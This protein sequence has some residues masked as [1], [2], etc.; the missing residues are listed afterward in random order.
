V[1]AYLA[2]D[3]GASSG[4]AILGTL[5]HGRIGLD[6]IHR[7]TTPLIE[8]GDHLTWD[9]D[10]LWDE[11]RLGLDRAHREVPDLRSVSVDSWAVDYVPVG[12]GGDALRHPYSYRDPRT[13]GRLTQVLSRVPPAELYRRTGIQLLEINTIYQLMADL[14]E[15][16]EMLAKTSCRLTIADYLLYRMSG[17]AGIERTMAS[18]TQLM[19]IDGNWDMDL[20]RR[21]GLPTTGWPEII[22]SGTVL[23]GLAAWPAPDED[24][25]LVIAS[26]SHDTAAAVAAVPASDEP[27]WAYLSSGTWSLMGVE[28]REPILTDRAREENFTNEAGLDDTFRVLKNLTGLWV[29][30]EC[31]REWRAADSSFDTAQVQREA[32]SVSSPTHV[33]DLNDPR[34]AERGNMQGKLLTCC[35]ELGVHPPETRAELVRLIVASLAVSHGAAL[36][37][38]EDVI[39]RRIDVLHVVGGG[40]QN[41]LLCDL[42]AKECGCRVVAGPAEATAIGNLLVQARTLGDLPEGSTLRDVVRA[43]TELRAYHPA[44]IEIP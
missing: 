37:R 27:G 16:P 13:R 34:L 44:R 1:S 5:N 24:A 43:S 31:E 4:R 11:V 23:G 41:E 29:L 38:L 6:E 36:R 26:C 8:R 30:Q 20:L 3:L 39:E 42:T 15:E 2:F 28:R 9:I 40:S 21:V 35:R 7:F 19:G 33:L 25:P 17:R 22:P 18:T 12:P 32:A 14:D 10:A